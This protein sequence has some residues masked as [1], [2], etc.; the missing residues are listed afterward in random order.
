MNDRENRWV[1]IARVKLYPS[2]I[3]FLVAQTKEHNIHSKDGHEWRLK[4][5]N[6]FQKTST[7]YRTCAKCLVQ[8]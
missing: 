8:K 7:S 6:P 2:D 4:P 3:N 5:I 1:E